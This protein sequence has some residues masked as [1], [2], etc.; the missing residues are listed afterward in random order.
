VISRLRGRVFYGWWMVT[1]GFGIQLLAAGLLGQ[2]YGAYLVLLRDDF[3]WS[4]TA[5]SGA[6]S[7]QQ[8]ES[9]LLGPVQ[10]WIID[11]FG[12]RAIMRV[13]LVIFGVGF[14]LL[15]Q[16]QSLPAFYAVILTM[17]IGNTLSG[18]FPLTV[19]IVNWFER[20][21]ARALSTMSLGLAV[22]GLVVPLVAYSL[23]TLGWRGTAFAS[24]VMIIAI[25]LPLAQV[26]RRRPEDY[27]EVMDG[28][29]Y[30]ARVAA[31][32]DPRPR[33]SLSPSR[34]FTAREAIR[35]PA[36]W[37][38]SL[39]HGS[40]LLVVTAVNVHVVSHLKED[41]GYSLAA[42]SLVVTLMTAFQ[43]AGMIIGGIVGDRFDKRL[44]AVVCMAMHTA[45]LLLVAYAVAL[46]M[47]VAF[48]VLHGLA[49]GIRGPLMQAIRADYFGRS[50]F[51]VIMGFSSMIVVLGTITGP[52]VA[53]VLADSTGSY[54]TGFTVLAL[55]AGL[56]SVFFLL[57]R[58]PAP[59]QLEAEP[60]TETS[61]VDALT[62]S[63]SR[64]S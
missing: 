58:R 4:K 43:V 26:I 35:T 62:V 13:G 33:P 21:R 56:G 8:L 10:G 9:G 39:G 18:F 28:H 23:E 24:G 52:L 5:L 25:G 34:D 54:E 20:Q 38:I 48:A 12:P 45:G 31:A 2:S 53:G 61:P 30:R 37:L 57:A 22:G 11:R 32:P 3:G 64:P 27:G 14:M 51:G 6:Y 55:L 15:S 1:A 29:R 59:P 60:A 63:E 16:V 46:P 40:A 50:A 44:I 19:A 49:W 41:V 36:F 42:A 17:A 7:L 47:V